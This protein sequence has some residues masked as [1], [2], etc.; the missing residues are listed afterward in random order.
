MAWSASDPLASGPCAE[1]FPG[2]EKMSD[3]PAAADRIAACRLRAADA[4]A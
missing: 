1:T 3:I 2:S 4:E